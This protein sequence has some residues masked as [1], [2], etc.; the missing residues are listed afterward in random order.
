MEDKKVDIMQKDVVSLNKNINKTIDLLSK[1]IK[2]NITKNMLSDIY[3][4]NKSTFTNIIISLDEMS[5]VPIKT[6]SKLSQQKNQI[7]KEE[8]KKRG[9]GN[10][11]CSN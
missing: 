5:L 4:T 2:C 1:S 3:E 6:I 7:L 10:A 8:K 9:E 11:S